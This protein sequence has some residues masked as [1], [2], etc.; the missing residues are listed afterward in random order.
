MAE[1][2][3]AARG[4]EE[5][6]RPRGAKGI[7][8]LIPAARDPKGGGEMGELKKTKG[9]RKNR[10]T[11]VSRKK[12]GGRGKNGRASTSSSFVLILV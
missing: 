2:T 4:L 10:E 3:L 6:E 9:G 7:G 11:R 5:V 1:A 12:S 8:E